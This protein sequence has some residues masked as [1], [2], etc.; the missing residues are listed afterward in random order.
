MVNIFRCVFA[1][2]KFIE[3]KGNN[4]ELHINVLVQEKRKS[5]VLVTHGYV[6]NSQCSL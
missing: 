1:N 6:H 2:K 3:I 4:I 5:S